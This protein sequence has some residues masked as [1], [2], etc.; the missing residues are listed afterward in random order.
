MSF[1]KVGEIVDDNMQALADV[2]V[3]SEDGFRDRATYKNP[4]RYPDGMK[5]VIVNGN[6]AFAEDG[7]KKIVRSGIILKRNI[8]A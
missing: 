4:F 7:G 3:F 1:S 2:V 8:D 5:C 6:I